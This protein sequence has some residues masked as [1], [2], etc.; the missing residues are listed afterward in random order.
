MEISLTFTV[1]PNLR[2]LG[3]PLSEPHE[4]P[5]EVISGIALGFSPRILPRI[6]L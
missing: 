3:I 1:R 4:I 5:S 6:Q 2:L